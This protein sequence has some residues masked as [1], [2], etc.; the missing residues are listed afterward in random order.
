[1]FNKVQLVGYLGQEPE[2][3]THKKGG[4]MATLS[5]ATHTSWQNEQGDW[6]QQTDWHQVKVFKELLVAWLREEK[7]KKGDLLFVQGSLRY[8]EKQDGAANKKKTTQIV[9][10]RQN[11]QI[12]QIIKNDNHKNLKLPIP[13]TLETQHEN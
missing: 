13:I 7:I 12:F 10:S 11:G 3:C 5:L 4:E 6:Q 1:M 9:V 8:L 2:I